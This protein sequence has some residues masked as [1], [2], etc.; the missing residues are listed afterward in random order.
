MNT[1]NKYDLS[2]EELIS[3][4]CPSSN[5][6]DEKLIVVESPEQI[7]SSDQIQNGDELFSELYG[8][9]IPVGPEKLV[10]LSDGVWIDSNG[11]LH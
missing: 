2:A 1:N 10:Y 7:L 11:N 6:K 9:G 5:E 8:M 3:R 4:L